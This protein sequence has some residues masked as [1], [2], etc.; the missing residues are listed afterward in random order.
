MAVAISKRRLVRVLNDNRH[1]FIAEAQD[2]LRAG[3]GT[4]PLVAVDD[5][6]ARH[7]GKN[8]FARG[9]A[10]SGSPGSVRG[11]RKAG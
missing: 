8:G 3:A 5:T 11:P 1:G 7:A 6:G 9:S 10:M 4:S 2:V